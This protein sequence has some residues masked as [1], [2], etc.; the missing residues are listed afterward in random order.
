MGFAELFSVMAT[1]SAEK[2]AEKKFGKRRVAAGSEQAGKPSETVSEV[3]T[4]KRSAAPA[5]ASDRQVITLSSKNMRYVSQAIK[6]A[7]WQRDG[8][9]CSHRGSSRNL[10]IDHIHPVAFG[11]TSSVENLRLLCF[12]CNQRQAIITFG[13]AVVEQCASSVR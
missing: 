11:G 9:R 10:N 2:L 5:R 13:L 6:H 8:S 7:V 1:L 3:E 12:S 4:V